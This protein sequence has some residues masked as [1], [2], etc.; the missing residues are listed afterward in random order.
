MST[1]Q[2]IELQ[3]FRDHFEILVLEDPQKKSIIIQEQ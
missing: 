3:L 1:I 2:L